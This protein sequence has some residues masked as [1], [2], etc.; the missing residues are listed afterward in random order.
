MSGGD[1]TDENGT[2]QYGTVRNSRRLCFEF[3][4]AWKK[5]IDTISSENLFLKSEFQFIE[6]SLE[7]LM[8]RLQMPQDEQSL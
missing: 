8:L 3:L 6:Q 1:R 2:E 5:D 4:N 7:L